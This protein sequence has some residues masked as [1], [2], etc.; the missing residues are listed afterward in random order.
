MEEGIGNHAK[1]D[2]LEYAFSVEM[3]ACLGV[4][5]GGKETVSAGH[6]IRCEGIEAILDI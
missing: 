4:L 5:D 1:R 2:S 6:N 3:D